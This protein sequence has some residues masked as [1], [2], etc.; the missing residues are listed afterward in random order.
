MQC[1][2]ACLF[3][4]GLAVFVLQATPASTQVQ[5]IDLAT[6]SGM[7]ATLGCGAGQA[8]QPRRFVGTPGQRVRPPKACD[9]L[10][11]IAERFDP[12]PAT[13][14]QHEFVLGGRLK[15]SL[16]SHV[17]DDRVSLAADVSFDALRWRRL[18]LSLDGRLGFD[19]RVDWG[20]DETGRLSLRPR[21]VARLSAGSMMFEPSLAVPS[22]LSLRQGERTGAQHHVDGRLAVS[23]TMGALKPSLMLGQTRLLGQA[24]ARPVMRIAP[25]LAFT[26]R[27]I[28][29]GLSYSYDGAL[30]LGGPIGA[31]SHAG[32]FKV[33]YRL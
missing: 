20:L 24:G 2:H 15:L 25:S 33:D 8:L 32:L 6:Q 27:R 21:I 31:G 18:Q 19:D 9:R 26:R 29:L 30:G 17:S 11:T 28:D 16:P 23:A 10:A 5:S 1:L 14:L 13:M 4:L 12:A 22:V 3:S 7:V